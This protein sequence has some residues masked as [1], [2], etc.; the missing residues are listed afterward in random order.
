M[1]H[2][3]VPVTH[4]RKMMLEELQ[5]RNYA[6]STVD[7]YI[8]AMREFGLYFNRPPDQLGPEQIRQPAVSAPSD[9][10]SSSRAEYGSTAD[11][12]GAVLLRPYP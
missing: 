3:E 1:G 7:T 6:Q 4:L 11:G 8:S 12:R 2:K 5:R 10:G 9:P